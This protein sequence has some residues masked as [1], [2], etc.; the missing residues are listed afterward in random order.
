MRAV[1]TLLPV[2]A[3]CALFGVA[4]SASDEGARRSTPTAPSSAVVTDDVGASANQQLAAVKAATAKYHDIQ[5]AL[6]D[7]FVPA[8]NACIPGEGIHY[9]APAAVPDSAIDCT[10]DP[11]SP[12]VLHYVPKPNGELQ[13]VGVEYLV[14][15][16]ASCGTLTA[17]PQGFSGDADEWEPEIGGTVWAL[18][19][20]IWQGVPDGIFAFRSDKITWD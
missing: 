15:R 9:R 20:W 4:C 2:A 18:N 8:P 5:Q 12:E 19:A 17:P 14:A 6:D 7:G 13:L 10:F 3:A 1:H 16:S 11:A